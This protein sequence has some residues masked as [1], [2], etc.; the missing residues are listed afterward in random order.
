[1]VCAYGWLC[2]SHE[3]PRALR[4]DLGECV[5]WHQYHA[6]HGV[7]QLHGQL[8]TPPHDPQVPPMPSTAVPAWYT[9][10][11]PRAIR[12]NPTDSVLRNQVGYTGPRERTSRRNGRASQEAS[13]RRAVRIWDRP[14]SYHTRS[15]A[16]KYVGQCLF[17]TA[18]D[19]G[20]RQVAS[21]KQ[22]LAQPWF[23]HP[24]AVH[25]ASLLDSYRDVLDDPVQQS[26]HWH[27]LLRRARVWTTSA[28]RHYQRHGRR[29]ELFSVRSQL[30]ASE[31]R[32]PGGVASA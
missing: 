31:R 5:A 28:D 10:L 16:V 9:K 14:Q 20:A 15:W 30:W 18:V 8:S 11:R 27:S 12:P 6:L 3:P 29:V 21:A 23:L 26:R 17:S 7:C 2:R 24:R 4:V 22:H 1:M 19:P 32:P 13:H 25:M